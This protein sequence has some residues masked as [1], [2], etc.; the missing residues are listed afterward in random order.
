MWLGAGTVLARVPGFDSDLPFALLFPPLG[1]ITGII[2]SGKL[3]GI[4]RGRGFDRASLP[5]F[6]GR[7]AASGLL[8]SGIFVVAAALRAG[9]PWGD[10]LLFGPPLAIAG[11]LCAT[12]SLAIARWAE[13]RALPSDS[14][15]PAVAALS[16]NGPPDPLRRGE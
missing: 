4:E 13:R 1:F 8:L 12:G 2:F 9:D 7:G 6:A 14:G 15:H 5:R 16:E 10:L 11:A 3:V